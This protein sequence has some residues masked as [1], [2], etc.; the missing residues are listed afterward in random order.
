MTQFTHHRAT[1]EVTGEPQDQ[2]NEQDETEQSVAVV[3]PPTL[4]ASRNARC[5]RQRHNKPKSNTNKMVIT[6]S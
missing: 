5:R 1:A 3:W 2:Q 6:R 4:P